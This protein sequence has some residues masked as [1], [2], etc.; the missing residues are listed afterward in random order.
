MI[1]PQP[2]ELICKKCGWSKTFAPASDVIQLGRDYVSACP[3]CGNSELQ[4]K[5]AE[6]MKG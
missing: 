5:A 2:Y 1:K 6:P 3:E 4:H